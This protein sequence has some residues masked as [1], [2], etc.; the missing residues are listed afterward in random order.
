MSL[1]VFLELNGYKFMVSNKEAVNYMV[2]LSTEDIH[3]GEIAVWI[4]Q[5]SQL[6]R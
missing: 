1:I 5:Y 4:R 3:E 6:S 2:E